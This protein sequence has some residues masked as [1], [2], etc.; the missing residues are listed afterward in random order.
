MIKASKLFC[1]IFLVAAAPLVQ[2]QNNVDPVEAAS[3]EAIRRQAL[4]IQLRRTLAEAQV[5]RQHND[6][7]GAHK[8]YERCFDYVTQIG[9]G[10]IESE[11]QQTVLGLSA[12]LFDMARQYQ[13]EHRYDKA[14]EQFAR[15]LVVDPTNRAAVDAR[16]ENQRLLDAQAG[17]IPSQPLIEQIPTWRT[18]EIRVATMVQDGKLLYEAGKLDEAEETLRRAYAEDPSNVAAYHYLQAILQKR[19]A[20]SSRQTE[21]GASED[22]LRVEKAWTANTRSGELT[23]HPNL[24]AR[25]NLVYTGK[26]R[27]LILAKLDRIHVDTV[28]YDDLPLT[29]VVNNLSEIARARDYD[30]Q[31][32]NFFIDR[33]APA[34]TLGAPGAIDPA[35]GLPVTAPLP[36][37]T[38]DISAVTVKITPALSEVRLAD[39]LDA[40]TKT[41]NKP[42]RYSVLDYAVVFALRGPEPVPLE[43]RT[44]HLDPNTFRNGL[45]SVSGIPFGN[46]SGSTGGSSGGGNSGGNSGGQNGQNGTSTAVLPQVQVTTGTTGGGTTGGGGGG[47]IGGGGG[48]NGNGVGLQ[49]VTATSN[50]TATLQTQARN[51]FA[52][53]GVDLNSNNPANIGKMFVWN[54]RKGVLMVRSTAQDL[55][56]I[57]Q[58]IQAL[59][60]A[61][62]QVNIKA[63]FIEI[64]QNDNKALGF[65]WFLG[66]TKIGSSIVGSGG[67]QPSLNGTPSS[68]NPLGTFPGVP[69]N[70]TTGTAAT[71]IIPQSS[72]GNIT[73]QTALRDTAPTIAT[74]TGIL[75]DPQFRVAIQALE[76]R[77]GVDE[78]NAP[79]VTTESGRQAQMQAVDIETIVTGTSVNTSGGAGVSG[80]ANGVNSPIV[81][82]V[83]TV[84]YP[85]SPLPIGPTL[86]VIPY[87]SADEFSVQ[88]TLIP[89][90]TEFL[91]YDNPGQ[92]VPAALVSGQTG[93]ASLAAV[94]PLPH[95]RL[96]Q[97]TTSVTVWDSQTVVLGGLM[98]DTVTKIK[99]KVP[100]L[101]DLPL[102]GRLFQSQS[103]SKTKKNL[104]IFVTATIINPDGTR[105][106]S[107][108][109]MPFLQSSVPVVQKASVTP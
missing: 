23:P 19:H 15:I 1:L 17:T 51:F 41:A 12:V 60:T 74:V 49:Y 81:Q 8:L 96:R 100:M 73:P 42:I 29:E 93:N 7:L 48:Q 10:G 79:E 98:T 13:A 91:G 34:A 55:D 52:A 37:D 47:N 103:A 30:K 83:P 44:F 16:R 21:L 53:V 76:Q 50:Y 65:N 69:A 3:A 107:D 46:I 72:D 85:T 31:G 43:T 90:I 40:I 70:L 89:S 58:A 59:N 4:T 78:L 97:V 36:T 24:F 82:Q 86:D 63:K 94:L 71:T 11:A 64:T 18:N 6:L 108:E 28:K 84:N 22:L 27:Q 33:Q 87:V 57:D 61:P 77:D 32:I 25:T 14:D 56:M 45:E 62:P 20:D 2:A 38:S 104:M 75:T 88:M 9:P 102:V 106:H 67:T 109:E 26:G 54:D 80:V 101:G 99:D 35:T 105:Y 66:N 5:A 95:F 92:F 39:V 68:A